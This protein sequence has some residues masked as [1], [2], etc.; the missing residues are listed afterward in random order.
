[1]S[2]ALRAYFTGRNPDRETSPRRAAHQ[3]NQQTPIER[4]AN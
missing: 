4:P 1:M 3:N 2:E